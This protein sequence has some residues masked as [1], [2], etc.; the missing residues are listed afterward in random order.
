M[1][2]NEMKKV[3]HKKFSVVESEGHY[4]MSKDTYEVPQKYSFEF[5]QRL[6]QNIN[7]RL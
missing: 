7:I 3:N 5:V 6:T 4:L 2:F 1:F